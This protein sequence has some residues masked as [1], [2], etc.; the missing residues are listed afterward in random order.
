MKITTI[1]QYVDIMDEIKQSK[2]NIYVMNE[3]KDRRK[4]FSNAAIYD[5]EDI[6]DNDMFLEFNFSENKVDIKI[7]NKNG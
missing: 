4:I 7:K 3:K 5:F 1:E 2:S 6:F